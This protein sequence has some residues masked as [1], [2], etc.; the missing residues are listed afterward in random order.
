M[1]CDVDSIAS[2]CG[3]SGP[4]AGKGEGR[5]FMG[6]PADYCVRVGRIQQLERGAA[7]SPVRDLRL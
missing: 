6:K 7:Y 4:G 3:C 2:W 5:P 1:R